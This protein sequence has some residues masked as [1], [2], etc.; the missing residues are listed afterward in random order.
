M[1]WFMLIPMLAGIVAY[2]LVALLL[3]VVNRETSVVATVYFFWVG[4][5]IYLAVVGLI[6]LIHHTTKSPK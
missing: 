2:P 1:A 4:T 5:L 6:K 3:S